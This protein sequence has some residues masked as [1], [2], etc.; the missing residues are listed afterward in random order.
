MSYQIGN[1][2][3]GRQ[4]GDHKAKAIEK[5]PDCLYIAYFRSAYFYF[6]LP[7]NQ[8]YS[9]CLFF[10]CFCFVVAV[11]RLGVEVKNTRPI[12]VNRSIAQPNELLKPMAYATAYSN[13]KSVCVT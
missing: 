7:F 6:R 2:G 8:N 10:D 12:A 5:Y 3:Q 13:V 9:N 11:L 1:L 4:G